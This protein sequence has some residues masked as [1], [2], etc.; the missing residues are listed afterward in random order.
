MTNQ[1][2][3][4]YAT[5]FS[6]DGRKVLSSFVYFHPAGFDYKAHAESKGWGILDAR[7]VGE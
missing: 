1:I 5:K 6:K 7:K 4:K 2:K 3:V